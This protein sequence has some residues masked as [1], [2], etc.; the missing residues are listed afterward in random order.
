MEQALYQI[1]QLSESIRALDDDAREGFG[2]ALSDIAITAR[3]QHRPVQPN[4]RALVIEQIRHSLRWWLDVGDDR[5][6]SQRCTAQVQRCLQAALGAGENDHLLK[7]SF[8]IL[9]AILEHLAAMPDDQREFLS[10]RI[11]SIGRDF[12]HRHGPGDWDGIN[13]HTLWSEFGVNN[14]P[15]FVC[16]LLS[17]CYEGDDY[18]V[19]S[20]ICGWLFGCLP[21]TQEVEQILQTGISDITKSERLRERFEWI[22]T[23]QFNRNAEQAGAGQPATRPVVDP[24]SGDKPQPE[25]E[26]R[27]R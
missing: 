7:G 23:R 5:H 21:A 13:L 19:V 22:Y 1:N 24:E 3:H 25:A 27:S 10:S 4:Q 11:E 15:D 17:W 18:Q 26:G 16:K 8:D 9:Y 14:Y 20:E 6:Y 12:Q 2:S